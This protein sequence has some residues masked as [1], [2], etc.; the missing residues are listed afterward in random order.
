MR[1]L[2][3]VWRGGRGLSEMIENEMCPSFPVI[4]KVCTLAFLYYLFLKMIKI[5]KSVIS[6]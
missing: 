6:I 2:Q 5:E 1:K 3:S 4:H